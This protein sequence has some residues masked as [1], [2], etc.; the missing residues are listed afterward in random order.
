MDKATHPLNEIIMKKIS[1]NAYFCGCGE[2][3][4]CRTKE[5][6]VDASF[7]VHYCTL[8]LNPSQS[9]GSYWCDG[10]EKIDLNKLTKK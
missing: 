8:N 1:V 7:N 3:K 10:F 5:S 6:I 4:R 2:C 9:Y